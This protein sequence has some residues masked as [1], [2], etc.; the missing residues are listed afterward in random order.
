M[1]K[2]KSRLHK[3]IENAQTLIEESQAAAR[4]TTLSGERDRIELHRRQHQFIV[5]VMG[6]AETLQD[7]LE[8]CRNYL[9]TAEAAHH[10]AQPQ[11]LRWQATLNDMRYV[12]ALMDKIKLEMGDREAPDVHSDV[13]PVD[14]GED[15]PQNV[16]N[17]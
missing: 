17:A 6:K 15:I 4:E 5:D 10:A 3:A 9:A 13:S 11:S 12:S 2:E 14:T 16:F 8:I 1:E 7:V